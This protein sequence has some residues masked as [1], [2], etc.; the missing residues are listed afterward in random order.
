MIVI[1]IEGRNHIRRNLLIMRI[2]QR[3]LNLF[4]QLI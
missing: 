1:S 3:F 2:D 4:F